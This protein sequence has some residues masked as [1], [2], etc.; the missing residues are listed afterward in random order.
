M[1]QR[2]GSVPSFLSFRNLIHWTGADRGL[3]VVC[4]CV[5]AGLVTGQKVRLWHLALQVVSR[6]ARKWVTAASHLSSSMGVVLK[7]S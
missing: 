6:P 3:A 7:G 4:V 2:R 5:W 1:A